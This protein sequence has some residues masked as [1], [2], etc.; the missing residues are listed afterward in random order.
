MLLH[1]IDIIKASRDYYYISFMFNQEIIDNIK[2]LEKREWDSELKKWK[3]DVY[4]LY[5]LIS[6]YKGRKDIFFQFES[7]E[8]R[9][10]FIK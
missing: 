8:S 9:A 4:N 2:K 3:L 7:D 10:E 6:F 1:Q 5:K